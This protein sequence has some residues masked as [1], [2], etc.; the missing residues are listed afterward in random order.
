[1]TT[2]ISSYPSYLPSDVCASTCTIIDEIILQNGA[3]YINN[4]DRKDYS[5]Q[6]GSHSRLTNI[7]ST[8]F[9]QVYKGWHKYNNVYG[10]STEKFDKI[11]N[12]S[13]KF[14]KSE[15]GGGFTAWHSE[16][17]PLNNRFAV[18][19]IYLN[20]IETGG[21]TEFKHFDLSIQPVAGTLL[22]WPASFTHLHRAAAD[23]QTNKYIATGWFDF[24][25][26]NS[27][28]PYKKFGLV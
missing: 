15:S 20:S 28:K 13:W 6:S 23:L 12:P 26:I 22:I 7:E 21:A 5:I 27:S 19:M 25:R 18:W 4:L 24:D 11:F 1:M 3:N 16:Q 10:A 8:I 17:A 14:Q 2:F 9:D